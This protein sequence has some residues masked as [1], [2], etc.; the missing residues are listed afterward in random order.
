MRRHIQ[1]WIRDLL[2]LREN[3]CTPPQSSDPPNRRIN[4]N[5]N[6]KKNSAP[7]LILFDAF[8]VLTGRAW[9]EAT[10]IRTIQGISDYYQIPFVSV[11]AML[12]PRFHH[13]QQQQQQESWMAVPHRGDRNRLSTATATSMMMKEQFQMAMELLYFALLDITIDFCQHDE[14]HQD[15]DLLLSPLLHP[16]VGYLAE[17]ILPPPLDLDLSWESISRKWKEEEAAA[18]AVAA[19]DERRD[20]DCPRK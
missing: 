15:E 18:A 14:Q 7:V 11:T 13:K 5:N 3:A 6:N 20:K 2:L 10:S 16:Q 4:N 12:A 1:V 19:D 17:H 9:N 8:S